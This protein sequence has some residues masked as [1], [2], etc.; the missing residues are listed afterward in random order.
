M[1]PSH[2]MRCHVSSGPLRHF[3]SPSGSGWMVPGR[4]QESPGVYRRNYCFK[5]QIGQLG[6]ACTLKLGPRQQ[7]PGLRF[8]TASQEQQL[9][10]FQHFEC[11][12]IASS[13]SSMPDKDQDGQLRGSIISNPRH[14][15]AFQQGDSCRLVVWSSHVLAPC[16]C[17]VRTKAVLFLQQQ[18]V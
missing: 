2:L 13:R 18:A 9:I 5:A 7:S 10:P 14:C 12:R 3:F 11:P 16:T 15:P 6:T 4:A 8:Q 1:P 17:R